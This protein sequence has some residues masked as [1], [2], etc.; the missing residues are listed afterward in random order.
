MHE[1]SIK[2]GN[3]YLIR[4]QQLA[5]GVAELPESAVIELAINGM[6]QNLRP[7]VISR[8]PKIFN[9]LRQ[10]VEI[11]NN[12]LSSESFKSIVR[13]EVMSMQTKP[14]IQ[15]RQNLQYDRDKD[16]VTDA[17][18][19]LSSVSLRS[20]VY[21]WK[22]LPFG[23]S[24]A[25]ASFQHMLTHVLHGLNYQMALVYVDDILVISRNFEE[26]MKHLQL[27]FDRLLSAGFTLKPSKC[28]FAQKRFFTLVTEFQGKVSSSYHPQ[29]NSV[30]ERTNKTIIQCMRTLVHENQLNWPEL[31]PGILKAFRMT[32]SAS[33]EFSPFYLVFGKEMNLPLDTSL[34]PK[35]D[36]NK[37]LVHH[38]KNVLDNM[39]IART[40]ATENL[41]HAQEYQKLHYDKNTE[42]PTFEI[43]D[44]VLMY[45]PKVPVGLSSKL[46]RRFD[47]P[48][49]IARKGLNHTYKLR[50]C[51][52]NKELK[53]MINANRLK[54]YHPPDHRRDLGA[55]DDDVPRQ[56]PMRIVP[57]NFVQPP[58]NDQQID[59]NHQL[60]DQDNTV[61]DA[62]V[63]DDAIQDINQN[64]PYEIS[65]IL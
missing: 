43:Q 15:E 33:L 4:I 36:I 55:P 34:I 12:I 58:Q 6:S 28:E 25:P 5:V 46:H 52:N 13:Q 39:K 24:S 57:P 38:I 35:S 31:L 51:S 11:A 17:G 32:P 14:Q 60:N 47:G 10:S 19:V 22:R 61:T 1:F 54:L 64:K 27:V 59:Q 42:K 53:S 7:H 3:Q 9:E 48:F 18:D 29:T 16:R 63:Q 20:G 56:D 49:Y 62:H 65:R 40:L 2:S 23:I 30:A 8:N 21:Q 41:K 44:Q 50:R 37:N 26:H 45:T